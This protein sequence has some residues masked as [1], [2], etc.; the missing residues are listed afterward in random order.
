MKLATMLG[1][2]SGYVKTPQESIE[3]LSQTPF[4]YLDFSFGLCGKMDGDWRKQIEE[5]G[6]LA[7]K[8]NMKFIQAHST[9]INLF[10]AK[11]DHE[12]E[13]C[14]FEK[15]LE[16]CAMLGIPNVVVHPLTIDG[17]MYPDGRNDFFAFNKKVY[18]Q[19]IPYME[20]FG[21]SVLI[22]NSAEQNMGGKYFFMTGQEM[23]DFLTE[24]NHPL[25]KAVW[26]TG[27]ANMRNN[28][29]Y[30]DIMA[31]GDELVGVHVH[32]NDGKV[33]EHTA[34]FMGIADFDNIIQGLIDVG[35]KGYFTLEAENFPLHWRWPY[36][37]RAYQETNR[38]LM[39]PLELKMEYEKLLYKTAKYLLDKFDIF[40]E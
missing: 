6:E 10:S 30:E 8:N 7:A 5:C 13:L 18:E 28:N 17:V 2:F 15:T 3:L 25:L 14:R 23:K 12:E 16:A 1:D 40:E 19:F 20:R 32:D 26:D 35:Y 11:H 33:D 27:H 9:D 21:V 29:Q 4:K 39:P 22:E 38:F 31:L 34:P 24:M 37:R 36:K